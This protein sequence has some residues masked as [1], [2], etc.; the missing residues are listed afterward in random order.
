MNENREKFESFEEGVDKGLRMFHDGFPDR[1]IEILILVKNQYPDNKKIFFFLGNAYFLTEMWNEAEKC[2][3]KAIKYY[4]NSVRIS[5]GL[6]H[7]LWKQNKIHE[8]VNELDR[9]LAESNKKS[10]EHEFLANSLEEYFD[11]V[12]GVSAA[13]GDSKPEEDTVKVDKG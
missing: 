10:E 13:N 12:A 4:P 2:Y 6:Y 1:S 3:R 5:L 11:E 9:F 7:S 8:A